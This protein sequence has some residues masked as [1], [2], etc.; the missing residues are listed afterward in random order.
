MTPKPIEERIL[1]I[2]QLVT[3]AGHH[4]SNGS[5]IIWLIIADGVSDGEGWDWKVIDDQGRFDWIMDKNT[6]QVIK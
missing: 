2:G 6:W 5:P 3:C 4:H 1:K